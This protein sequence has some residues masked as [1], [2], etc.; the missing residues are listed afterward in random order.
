VTLLFAASLGWL[1]P[2]DCGQPD[3]G[4]AAILSFEQRTGIIG[5]T[6]AGEYLPRYV[7]EIPDPN[8]LTS[9]Y[10]TEGPIERLDP[11]SLAEGA[12]VESAEYRLTSARLLFHS[13]EPFRA[14]YRAFYFPGWRVAVK[15]KNAP[16]V[17]TAPHGLISFDVPAGQTAVQIWFGTTPLRVGSALLSYATLLMVLWLAWQGRHEGGFVPASTLSAAR[18]W[19]WLILAALSGGLLWLKI[20]VVDT[21]RAWF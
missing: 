3:D 11:T 17:I 18:A 14:V 12:T 7:Q 4:I 15:G 2:Q 5:T 1:T 9:L 21:G 6:P 19:Q 16:I 10:E 13:P 20:A 8:A